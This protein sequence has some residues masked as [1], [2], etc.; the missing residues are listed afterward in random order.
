MFFVLHANVCG[1]SIPH[2]GHSHGGGG[3][4]HSHGNNHGHA[5]EEN[6]GHAHGD[7]HGHAHGDNHGHAHNEC[8]NNTDTIINA[9]PLAIDIVSGQDGEQVSRAVRP[10]KNINLRAAIIH[11]IGDFVQSV[12]VL[13]AAILIKF[14]V[15]LKITKR[16]LIILFLLF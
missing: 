13:C 16:K 9:D 5:H 8:D 4:G 2:H 12:G 3:H 14:K 1:T 7:H 6:H 10:T 11:V 15:Y